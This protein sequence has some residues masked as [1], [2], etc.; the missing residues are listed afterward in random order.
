[1]IALPA[2]QRQHAGNEGYADDVQRVYRWDSLVP[3]CRRV[4][5]GDI[6]VL[7][8][9]RLLGLARVTR[10]EKHHGM[11]ELSR[12]PGCSKTGI[13][14]RQRRQPVYRC[15]G[16]GAEFDV[17]IRESRDVELYSA[18]F[19][20]TF[21]AAPDALSLAELRR[22][23]PRFN[24]QLAMQE[25]DLHSFRAIVLDRTPAARAL[26]ERSEEST[27]EGLVESLAPAPSALR[28][29]WAQPR[30]FDDTKGIAAYVPGPGGRASIEVTLA[31][32][33]KAT[34]S[35]HRLVSSL[36]RALGGLNWIEIQE[37]PAA[38]DLWAR[39]PGDNIRV[40]FEAK[41]LSRRNHAT[42]CR[43]ALAQLLEY[44]FLFGCERDLLCIVVDAPL[45][46]TRVRFLNALGI[47]AVL[48]AGDTLCE[49]G[50]VRVIQSAR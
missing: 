9:E 3:N 45:H 50:H 12:C 37:I 36:K 39:R 48:L 19:G 46:E 40:I 28:P 18:H 17:P 15:G 20:D 47:A 35:H 7:R 5:E 16:C 33:E 49:L 27:A 21:V 34:R 43:S 29:G 25:I 2:H 24:G 11:K 8:S 1:M 42:Q 6:A 4:R 41:T 44:R 30:D 10:I 13:K 38:V 32:A 31:L 23:C 22:A 26:F 14:R